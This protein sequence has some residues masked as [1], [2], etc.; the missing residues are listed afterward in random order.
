M[1]AA[2]REKGMGSGAL[3]L[4]LPAVRRGRLPVLPRSQLE[5]QFREGAPPVTHARLVLARRF[6]KRDAQ[7]IREKQRVVTETAAAAR[8]FENHPRTLTAKGALSRGIHI[9]RD[10]HITRAAIARP[11]QRGE[12]PGVVCRIERAPR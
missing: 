11:T 10:A 5:Q 8:R 12:Q 7:C 6:A 9:R 4:T 2:R 1:Y 3:A